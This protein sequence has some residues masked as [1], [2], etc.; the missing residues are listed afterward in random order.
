MKGFVPFAMCFFLLVQVWHSHY[1]Y[2]RRYGLQTPY[3]VLLNS[4]LLFVVL[5]YVIPSNSCLL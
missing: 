1:I 4:A 5:F 2:S 3:C